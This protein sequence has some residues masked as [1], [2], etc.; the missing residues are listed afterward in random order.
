MMEWAKYV[1]EG[2]F[3]IIG[4]PLFRFQ[5]VEMIHALCEYVADLT[6]LMK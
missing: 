5:S 2:I 6:S 4:L 3:F 1:G